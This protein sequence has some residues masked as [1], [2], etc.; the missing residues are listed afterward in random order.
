MR[1]CKNC[2]A[3][4][5]TEDGVIEINADGLC[6]ECAENKELGEVLDEDARREGDHDYSM[7]G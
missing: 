6:T 1:H 7:N 2:L 3:P 5:E 4:E